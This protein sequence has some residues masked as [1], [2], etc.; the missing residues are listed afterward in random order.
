[1]SEVSDFSTSATTTTEYCVENYIP[2]V[3]LEDTGAETSEPENKFIELDNPIESKEDAFKF[4][5][6]PAFDEEAFAGG[7]KELTDQIDAE[8][9]SE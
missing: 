7:L 1:M 3:E 8:E 5:D 2:E 6:V 9:A 4:E